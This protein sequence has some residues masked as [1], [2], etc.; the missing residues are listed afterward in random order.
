MTRFNSFI[1]AFTRTAKEA[2]RSFCFSNARIR[3]SGLAGR[4][5]GGVK[6]LKAGAFWCGVLD[7]RSDRTFVL[8]ILSSE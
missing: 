6:P 7:W 5:L 3:A 1:S 8:A 2:K 4:L